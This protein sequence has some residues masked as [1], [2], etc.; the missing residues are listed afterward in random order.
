MRSHPRTCGIA[1]IVTAFVLCAISL[2]WAQQ[3]YPQMDEGLRLEKEGKLEEALEVYRKVASEMP[4]F[5]DVYARMAYT[6]KKMEYAKQSSQML[7]KCQSIGGFKEDSPYA[8][9]AH[10]LGGWFL[11]DSMVLR[12]IS[13]EGGLLKTEAAA[14][15]LMYSSDDAWV[16]MMTKQGD[17]VPIINNSP[18]IGVGSELRFDRGDWVTFLG[19][20]YRKGGVRVLKTGL[21]FLEG[22]EQMDN[23]AVT[24]LRSGTWIKQ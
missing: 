1:T 2:A 9:D 4:Q 5:A 16:L 22:T 15:A 17:G 8:M 14:K 10:F 23:A 19:K 3:R 24:V 6:L 11:T 7:D 12:A 21:E 20:Q 13:D 18:T